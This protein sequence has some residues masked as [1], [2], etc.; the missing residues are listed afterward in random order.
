MWTYHLFG[1]LIGFCILFLKFAVILKE[2]KK[3]LD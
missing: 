2:G 1:L 3:I